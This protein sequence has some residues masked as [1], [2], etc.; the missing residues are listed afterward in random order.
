MSW[1][2]PKYHWICPINDW[3]CPKYNWICPKFYWICPKYDWIC[4]KYD[5][6][7]PKYDCICPKYDWICPQY[8]LDLQILMILPLGTAC[9]IVATCQFWT[10]DTTTL[11]CHMSRSDHGVHYR[12]NVI[13]GARGCTQQE[14]EG[15]KV[16]LHRFKTFFLLRTL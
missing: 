11:F 2:C 14:E 8:A 15:R 16:H 12:E 9:N 3:I 10:Y 6:I 4:P 1:I 5:M 13:S 7:C